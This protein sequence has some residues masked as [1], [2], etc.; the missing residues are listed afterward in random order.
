MLSG[1]KEQL[2]EL[3]SS[4]EKT[5]R[6]DH[7]LSALTPK[8]LLH[9]DR[10]EATCMMTCR[11]MTLES[12]I[13]VAFTAAYSSFITEEELAIYVGHDFLKPGG[14]FYEMAYWHVFFYYD[15][16]NCGSV[17]VEGGDEFLVQ[18]RRQA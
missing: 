4:N 6:N 12:K 16:K 15:L 2:K 13:F 9:L 11:G 18:D 1:T 14:Y 7:V 8:F 3:F 5:F 17:I 10:I